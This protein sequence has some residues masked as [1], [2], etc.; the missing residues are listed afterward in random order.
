[1][2]SRL[3]SVG[4]IVARSPTLWQVEP[5]IQITRKRN[6]ERER[7]RKGDREWEGVQQRI[8][9]PRI[10]YPV[11]LMMFKAEQ[12]LLDKSF[13]YFQPFF[14]KELRAALVNV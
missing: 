10:G 12:R 6:G 9:C 3:I 1:M 2:Y 5:H 13:Y 14:L 4:K 8:Y 7:G 11:E